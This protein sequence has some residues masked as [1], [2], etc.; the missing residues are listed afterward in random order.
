[1]RF[2]LCC[3]L[4]L[5]GSVASAQRPAASDYDRA[6]LERNLRWMLERE[7]EAG[8]E[9]VRR[10]RRVAVYA[11][12]GVWHPGAR[13]V[14]EAL[15]REEVYC[16]TIDRSQLT[17]ENLGR[18]DALVLPGGWAPSQWAG[19]G[20]KGLK[21]IRTFVERGGRCVGICAGA[22]LISRTVKYEEKSYDYPLGLHD[23]AAVGPVKGLAPF[24][25][26]GSA[27]LRATAAG[28]ARGLGAVDKN[29]VYYSGGPWFDGGAGVTILAEYHDGSAAAISR[30]VGRGE[31]VLI[32]GHVER[33]PPPAL[34]DA[35][36]PRWAG[37]VLKALVYPRHVE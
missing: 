7:R 13:S 8:R 26:P 11:D 29:E 27:R 15:E 24:P 22:Y 21:A 2:V 20:E 31:V 30:Q 34:D 5:V 36:S 33:P 4:L 12:D 18:F 9:K 19:A 14:V 6:N 25:K 28:R 23:G 35:A 1:M 37:G 17:D 16:V 32:G 10:D 3:S